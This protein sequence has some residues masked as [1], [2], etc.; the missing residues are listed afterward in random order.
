M[1]PTLKSRGNGATNLF[2]YPAQS[3]FSGVQHPLEWIARAQAKGWDVLL[4]AAAFV[5]TN[6]LDLSQYHP[7]FV[8]ISFYKMF[9]YPTGVGCLIVKHTALA[10]LK[11]PWFAGGTVEV[12]SIQG[13]GYSLHEGYAAFEDGTI[14][15]FEFGGNSYRVATSTGSEYQKNS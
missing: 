9:G 4:D 2:A 5:P 13:N 3:N 1:I 8:D 15:F 11:R 12:V 6:P 14:K 7:D 10:K